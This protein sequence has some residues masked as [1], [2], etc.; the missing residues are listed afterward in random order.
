[1]SGLLTPSQVSRLGD[2]LLEM[3]VGVGSGRDIT[4]RSMGRE[5]RAGPTSPRKGSGRAPLTLGGSARR[6]APCTN[7]RSAP[8]RR[9]VWSWLPRGLWVLGIG[10]GGG[11]VLV[12]EVY[13]PG[14]SDSW[15]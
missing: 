9:I 5:G 8:S 15:Y 7:V 12:Q 10:T 13:P 14:G 1:M 3:N 2:K 6:L 4:M 11:P